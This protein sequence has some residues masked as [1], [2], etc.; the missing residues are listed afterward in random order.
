VKI[1]VIHLATAANEAHFCDCFYQRVAKRFSRG[2]GVVKFHFTNT[3]V[4]TK[5]FPTKT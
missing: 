2:E 3:T 5:H 4:G 1:I